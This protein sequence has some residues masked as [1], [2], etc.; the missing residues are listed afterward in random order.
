MRRADIERRRARRRHVAGGAARHEGAMR[1]PRFVVARA[2]AGLVG[3]R[4]ADLFYGDRRHG[5]GQRGVVGA[6]GGA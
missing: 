1:N 3:T 5:D 4:D 6:G 2:G